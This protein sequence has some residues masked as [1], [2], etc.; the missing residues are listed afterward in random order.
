MQVT[1]TGT[2]SPAD[3]AN[4]VMLRPAGLSSGRPVF[5][6]S[7]S[8]TISDLSYLIYWD[9]DEL[10]WGFYY[11]S[12]NS[13]GEY[14]FWSSTED[15]PSP[16][17]VTTWSPV[18]YG[19]TGNPVMSW[20]TGE[21]ATA[22]IDPT[23]TDNNIALEAQVIG[24]GGNLI[25]LQIAAAA[26]QATTTINVA[27]NAITATP[28]S[29]ARMTVNGTGPF[30][31][32]FGDPANINGYVLYSHGTENGKPSYWPYASDSPGLI[33]GSYSVIRWTGSQ[34]EFKTG[35]PT[36]GY[37]FRAYSSENVATP[38]L[39]TAWTLDTSGGYALSTGT[40]TGMT[41]GA[42]CAQQVIDA[43]NTSAA[44]AALVKATA[45]GLATGTVQATGP[46]YLT[47][48]LAGSGIAA[49]PSIHAAPA[50]TPGNPPV[51]TP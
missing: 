45:S 24:S 6:L 11:Q 2:I 35:F 43:L 30:T 29:K 22:L 10:T 8:Q 13:G 36:G 16:D 49:P 46:V 50:R 34:W 39:V 31:D 21:F 9:P 25:S 1:I 48:G 18:G 23:G 7:G 3:A 4:G 27:G 41:A 47:G 38:D 20:V 51:I 15:V 12:A 37:Y 42:S 19:A 40:V 28:G 14:G 17:L 32:G 26:A 5:S 44:A 33:T